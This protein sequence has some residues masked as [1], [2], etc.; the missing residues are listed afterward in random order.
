LK[1]T[2]HDYLHKYDNKSINNM[3]ALAGFSKEVEEW[4]WEKPRG[5]FEVWSG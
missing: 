3:V 1:L 4:I 2:H 5:A